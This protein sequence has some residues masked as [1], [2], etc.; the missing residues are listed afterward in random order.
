MINA[1]RATEVAP[2]AD[3]LEIPDAS[4][5]LSLLLHRAYPTLILSP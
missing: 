1:R 4:S 3:G 2:Q 5:L